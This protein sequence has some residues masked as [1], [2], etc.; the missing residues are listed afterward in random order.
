MNFLKLLCHLVVPSDF[1]SLI[2]WRFADQFNS[3]NFTLGMYV[4]RWSDGSQ[5]SEVLPIYPVCLKFLFSHPQSDPGLLRFT[6]DIFQGSRKNLHRK[7][8]CWWCKWSALCNLHW[9]LAWGKAIKDILITGSISKSTLGGLTYFRLSLFIG[10]FPPAPKS[11]CI[12]K[13]TAA[14][15]G[16]KQG[17]ISRCRPGWMEPAAGNT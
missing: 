13:D 6:G 1:L 2:S 12:H 14:L 7:K 5:C 17:G 9:V 8:N 15:L 4:S 11:S 16:W 3:G 10:S